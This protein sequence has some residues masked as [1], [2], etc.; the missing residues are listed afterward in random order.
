MQSLINHARMF[1]RHVAAQADRYAAL[2]CGQ[3]PTALF[4][5]CSDSR[6]IPA[7]VTGAGPGEL[8]ELRTAGNVVPPFRPHG[9]CAVAAT[10]QYAV[11][12]LEVTDIV[13]CG[14]THCGA[15]SALA[16]ATPLDTLPLVERWLAGSRL[17]T[18][19]PSIPYGSRLEP[20]AQEHLRTQLKH[21][22]TYPFVAERMRLGRLGLH[23][24][25]YAVDTGAVTAHQV[26]TNTFA[27]L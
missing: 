4:V 10:L 13:I 20:Q 11:E 21:I 16:G 19:G 3:Q 27:P 17:A 9:T 6:V 15:V 7:L 18:P 1:P 8:F 14:H 22:R 24:W 26:Q 12:V 25:I 23:G 5:A 2:A